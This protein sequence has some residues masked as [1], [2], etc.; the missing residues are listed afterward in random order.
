MTE[1]RELQVRLLLS[2]QR[3]LLGEVTPN[4]RAV[5]AAIDESTITLRWIIDGEI[6]DDFRIDLS[7]VGA[8]IVADFKSHQIAEEFLRCD[9]PRLIRDLYLDHI[10]YVR[11]E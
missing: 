9:A 10:A 6:T 5:T 8:E 1:L 4:I 11:K 3:A 2:I 7:A